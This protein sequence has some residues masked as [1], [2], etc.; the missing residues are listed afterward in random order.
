MEHFTTLNILNI[1]E[2]C[3]MLANYLEHCGTFQKTLEYS[4][5]SRNIVHQSKP[6]VCSNV[7]FLSVKCSERIK[8]K[9]EVYSKRIS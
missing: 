7:C 2:C 4:E 5:M 6:V 9:G 3:G 1:S 8:T